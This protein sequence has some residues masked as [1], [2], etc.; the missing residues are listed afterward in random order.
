MSTSN[1]SPVAVTPLP[2]RMLGDQVGALGLGCMGMSEFYGHGDDARSVRTIHAALDAGVNL[3]DTADLYGDG[4]NERLL[5]LA[6]RGHRDQAYL[7]TKFA[8]RRQDGHRWYDS[9]PEYARAACEASL[10]R[11]GIETIDLYYMHRLDGRTP[12]EDTMAALA[13]LVQAGKVRYIGLSEVNAEVL[14]RAHAIHPVTAVQS[15]YSLWTRDVAADGVLGAARELGMVL[16][17]YS[18]LGRGFLTGSIRST[19]ALTERDFRRSN[20]RF[21]G[22]NLEANLPMLDALTAVADKHDATSGQV[23]LAWV[24]AQ[25]P[26]IVPIPGT[27]RVEYLRQ[28]I[29][30]T[31]L[32]LTAGELA[33]LDQAFDPG[34]VRGQR[35]P[36]AGMPI[37]SDRSI[38]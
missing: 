31:A 7:A 34:K 26:D 28:N 6:L 8:I 13:E 11:L 35:Y 24:L 20:P 33:L 29:A 37:T 36:D 4:H 14:R 15:E 22:S 21:T 18:P 9:S 25:G 30:A 38:K 2:Q 3:L 16:V 5:G 17:A 1:H 32:S 10:R 12:I 19:E 23:S 27:K